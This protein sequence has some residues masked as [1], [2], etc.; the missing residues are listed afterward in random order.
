M[1]HNE[2]L[3]SAITLLVRSLAAASSGSVQSTTDRIAHDT[4][5]APSTVYRW[6]QGR[7]CPTAEAIEILV[8]TGAMQAALPRK[9]GER[10][11]T[12]ARYRGDH[13]AILRRFWPVSGPDD[14]PQTRRSLPARA[15]GNFLGRAE[16]MERVVSFLSDADPAHLIAVT[17]VGGVGK[18]AFAV[19]VAH[20]MLA[21]P[22]QFDTVLFCSARRRFISEA[23]QAVSAFPVES[24]SDILRE[25]ALVLDRPDLVQGSLEEGARRIHHTLSAQRMLLIVDNL[26][27]IKDRQRT[28]GFLQEL[29]ST[30]KVLVTSR[31]YVTA[32][33]T[34]LVPFDRSVGLEYVQYLADKRQLNLSPAEVHEVYSRTAGI[35]GLILDATEKL[36]HGHSIPD[37]RG[38]ASALPKRDG[39]EL[40]AFYFG[41]S[42]RGIRD[43]IDRAVLFSLALVGAADMGSSRLAEIAGCT[44]ADADAGL[45]ALRKRRLVSVCG[46]S[47]VL[48]EPVR[49]FVLAQFG[50]D[51]IGAAVQQ[52]WLR[53]AAGPGGASSE[54]TP[55]QLS[56]SAHPVGTGL[57]LHQVA[58]RSRLLLRPS[59]SPSRL[60]GQRRKNAL[61]ASRDFP[62]VRAGPTK[63]AVA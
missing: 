23:G 40:L 47:H 14:Q 4:S 16:E 3:G 19:E 61:D 26:E 27:G 53:L 46:A 12:A 20:R 28:L 7:L 52:R 8:E 41:Q 34:A 11:L 60:R 59:S 25:V 50:T 6:R 49:Q 43:D 35:P 45:R 55:L 2:P 54:D 30:V 39:D 32:N 9:W 22:C 36:A 24:M 18:T 48:L 57:S 38:G 51:T 15:T 21:K 17:G 13:A 10:L 63:L 42:V 44:C 37:S 1:Y 58:A 5:Y 33:E 29:P 31:E 62:E 56:E